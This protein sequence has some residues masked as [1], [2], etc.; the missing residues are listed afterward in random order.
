M[1]HTFPSE[2][3]QAQCDW[4]AT[5][6]RL[7]ESRGGYT[8]LRRRLHRRTVQIHAHPYWRT[9]PGDGTAPAARMELKEQARRAA[10]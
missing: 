5:Y 3:L 2:L 1:A 8:A 10:A 7:A 4:Y 9:L 6:R